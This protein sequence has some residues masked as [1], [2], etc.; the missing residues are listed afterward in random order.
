MDF[1]CLFG[2]SETLGVEG[3]GVSRFVHGVLGS[4]DFGLN[5]RFVG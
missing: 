5:W 1:A 2:L 4:L 3:V